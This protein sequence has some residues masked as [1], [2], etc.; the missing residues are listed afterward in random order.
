MHCTVVFYWFGTTIIPREIAG[1]FNYL[2]GMLPVLIP[3]LKKNA[4]IRNCFFFCCSMAKRSRSELSKVHL[5]DVKYAL[6]FIIT[7]WISVYFFWFELI[8]HVGLRRISCRRCEKQSQEISKNMIFDVFG[9]GFISDDSRSWLFL[10]V[11]PSI[12][13]CFATISLPWNE[14]YEFVLQMFF[15]K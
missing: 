6:D 8:A 13:R 11:D 9:A 3:L 7:T 2:W 14:N 10:S 4:R 5:I 1:S 12:V 15:F